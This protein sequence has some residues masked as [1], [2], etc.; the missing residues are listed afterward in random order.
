[1]S[2][3]LWDTFI[4]NRGW[5]AWVFWG[6]VILATIFVPLWS[7]TSWFLNKISGKRQWGRML[8]DEMGLHRRW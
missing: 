8:D 1:M 5:G 4:F 3:S 2:S 6:W 7:F